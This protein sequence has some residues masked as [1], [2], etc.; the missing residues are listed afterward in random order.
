M[1]R[2]GPGLNV[3]M[4][5][6]SVATNI[7]RRPSGGFLGRPHAATHRSIKGISDDGLAVF[8]GIMRAHKHVVTPNQLNDTA[9]IELLEHTRAR[10][11]EHE[12]HGSLHVLLLYKRERMQRC[13]VH[14]YVTGPSSST[15]KLSGTP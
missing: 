10:V 9:L 12:L 3:A 6:T 15:T 5:T 13:A 1:R 11:G 7:M 2:P 4:T 14:M 8:D